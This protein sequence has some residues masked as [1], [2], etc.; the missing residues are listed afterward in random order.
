MV[1]NVKTRA[2]L[3]LPH[4]LFSCD[5]V[6]SVGLEGRIPLISGRYSLTVSLKLR[7]KCSAL[8]VGASPPRADAQKRE[9]PDRVHKTRLTRP[10]R[11]RNQ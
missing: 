2:I 9:T 11:S 1:V 5:S 3:A 8:P 6:Y 4:G 10:D 7:G